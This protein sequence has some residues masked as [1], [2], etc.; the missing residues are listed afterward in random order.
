MYQKDIDH[1][2]HFTYVK[3]SAQIVEKATAKVA[4]LRAKIE[5]RRA[6]I[7]TIRTTYEITDEVLI[8]LLQ[9]ARNQA[10]NA[11]TVSYTSNA[12]VAQGASMSE[13]TVTVPAGV[14]NNLMTEQDFIAGEQ[15]QIRDLKLIIRN[16]EDLPDT[17]PGCTDKRVG[18]TLTKE[19]L[20]YLGF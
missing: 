18:H 5:E 10:R 17:R 19:E 3:S 14:V 13:A 6:R 2:F 16:L 8:D 4:A 11:Q 12:R 9:Q 1:M 20:V 15:A 7:K